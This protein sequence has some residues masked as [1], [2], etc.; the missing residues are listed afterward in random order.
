MQERIKL[1]IS[2]TSTNKINPY[3]NTNFTPLS[4]KLSNAIEITKKYKKDGSPKIKKRYSPLTVQVYGDLMRRTRGR[5]NSRIFPK[6]ATIAESCNCSYGTV[7]RALCKLENDLIIFRRYTGRSS[8]YYFVPLK[9]D[10]SPDENSG[11][12]QTAKALLAQ[13][14]GESDL[15]KSDISYNKNETKIPIG[16][17]LSPAEKQRSAKKAALLS[18]VPKGLKISLAVLKLWINIALKYFADDAEFVFEKTFQSENPQ[19]YFWKVYNQKVKKTDIQKRQS[20]KKPPSEKNPPPNPQKSLAFKEQE[21]YNQELKEYS[22]QDMF[23]RQGERRE[24]KKEPGL[25]ARKIMERMQKMA[26]EFS[27]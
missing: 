19:A 8:F 25:A 26:I 13:K 11:E 10:G 17:F 9:D 22:D 7:Q 21:K 27:K 14:K 18:T 5:R 16:D 24:Q 23:M 2:A 3:K 12:Y 4:D 6:I 20:L 1:T 15:A